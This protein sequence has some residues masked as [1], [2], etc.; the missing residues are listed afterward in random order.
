M[1]EEIIDQAG[2]LTVALGTLAVG[3]PRGLDDSLI[4]AEVVHEPDESLVQ[5]RELLVQNR[6]SFRNRCVRQ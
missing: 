4:T 2:V 1:T 3:N 6:L 5:N